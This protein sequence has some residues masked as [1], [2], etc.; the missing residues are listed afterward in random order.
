MILAGAK[1]QKRAQG[2]INAAILVALLTV[3][4]IAYILFLPE[5]EREAILEG[6]SI[7]SSSGVKPKTITLLQESVGRLDPIENVRDKELPNINIFETTNAKVLETFAPVTVRNGW[8]EK[9]TRELA[10]NVKDPE[11]ANNVLLTFTAPIRKGILSISLNGALIYEFRVPGINVDPIRIRKGLLQEQNTLAF[12]VSS[13][14]GKFWTVNEYSLE[15]I[16]IVGDISDV[17][18]QESQNVFSLSDKEVANIEKAEMRFS[19]FCISEAKV[20]VLELTLNDQIAYS[21][22]PQC[23]ERT[24]VDLPVA[25]LEAQNSVLFK[26]SKGSYSIEQIK[27]TFTEKDTPETVFFFEVN[28]TTFDDIKNG[29]FDVFL[30]IE[31]VD[32]EETKRADLDINDRFIRIDQTKKLFE[33][34]LNSLIEDGNNFIKIIPREILDVVEVRVEAKKR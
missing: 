12:S 19:P 10:F 28:E 1:M 26:T 16:K 24:K 2:G 6:E 13:V 14:G 32:E 4:I 8:F 33:R 11:N 15:N 9:K 20:G 27:L 22:I 29:T 7:S 34:N 21:A 17:S 31:F 3:F 25:A 30:K 5:D 18:K 23:G